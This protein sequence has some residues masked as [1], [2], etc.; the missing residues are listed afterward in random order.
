MRGDGMSGSNVESGVEDVV[1]EE[2]EGA[3]CSVNMNWRG[4][5]NESKIPM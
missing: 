2:E 3:G 1:E 4:N 5:R